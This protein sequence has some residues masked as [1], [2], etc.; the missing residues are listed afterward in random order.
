MEVELGGNKGGEID[1]FHETKNRE[2][3]SQRHARKQNC[4]V[5][6]KNIIKHFDNSHRSFKK[7]LFNRPVVTG[8][9]LAQ[10]EEDLQL[11][12]KIFCGLFLLEEKMCSPTN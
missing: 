4:A 10:S 6:M 2:T 3:S 7:K 1:L 5:S 12:E 9:T 8:H 11:L